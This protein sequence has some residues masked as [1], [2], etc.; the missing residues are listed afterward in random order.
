MRKI[1]GG[2]KKWIPI[3]DFPLR[4]LSSG[5]F[6]RR[7]LCRS[8]FNDRS[9]IYNQKAKEK[10]KSENPEKEIARRRTESKRR[11]DKNPEPFR[12]RARQYWEKHPERAKLLHIVRQAVKNGVLH[13]P[14]K[15]SICSRA[16]CKIEA[17]H[18]DYGK[19]LNVVWSCCSCHQK[20]ERGIIECPCALQ[21]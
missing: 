19:P 12:V 7:F 18:P 21:E 15:C 1:C 16:K 5:N 6:G 3:G 2:C 11:F 9:K 10:R 8:C 17:H 13:K 4:K 20:I 14:S